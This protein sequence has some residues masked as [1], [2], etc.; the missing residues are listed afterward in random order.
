MNINLE[1]DQKQITKRAKATMNGHGKVHGDATFTEYDV[2]GWKYVHIRVELTGD[3][4]VLVPG[5][6]A[7]HIHE[8]AACDCDDFKCA[9]GHFDPGTNGN[10][11][12]DV[13]HGYHAGDLPMITIDSEGSGVLEAITTRITLSDGPVSI[14]SK[15][16]APEGTSIMIHANIDPY[17]PGESGSGI[18]GG[19]RLACGTI[20]EA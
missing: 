5:K 10:T 7:V 19:P 15:K 17:E 3:S 18:S 20:E 2:D 13:N 14:L 8:K 6:H 4:S 12:P 16:S 9:G 11:D 1:S